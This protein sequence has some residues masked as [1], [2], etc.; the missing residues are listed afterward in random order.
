MTRNSR[1]QDL[2]WFLD[3]RNNKQLDLDPP[4]QRKSVWAPKDRRFYMD[5]VMNNYPSPAIFLHKETK[6]DG[7][8]VYNVIDGK[9]RLET[10]FLFVDNKIELSDE[11]GDTRFSGEKFEDLNLDQK[12]QLWNYIIPVDFL[13]S[14]DKET[15]RSTFDRLNRNSRNLKQQEIRH[16][17]F[18]GWLIKFVERESDKEFWSDIKVTTTASAKRMQNIQFISELLIVSVYR[19]IFGFNQDDLNEKYAQLD[20]LE[21]TNFE[22]EGLEERFQSHKQIIQNLESTSGEVSKYA[23]KRVDLYT[24]WSCVALEPDCDL[25]SYLS[26]YGAFMEM[27]LEARKTRADGVSHKNREV[28]KYVENST[29]ASTDHTKRQAR[30]KA[31]WKFL[32]SED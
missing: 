22:A 1:P 26:S 7:S 17:Q 6:E 27:V 2:S 9:Q 18:D 24:L 23:T 31:L 20:Q 14:I 4:Y 11:F 32:S 5:T 25:S 12:K 19:K 3:L 8:T 10:V 16:A 21:E 30:Y 13:D 15:L 29:G 28:A